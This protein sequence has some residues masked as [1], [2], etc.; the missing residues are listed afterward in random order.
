MELDILITELEKFYI[1]KQTKTFYPVMNPD[2]CAEIMNY[3]RE[4]R[5]AKSG[6]ELT[7]KQYEEVVKQNKSLQQ[8]PKLFNDK[9]FKGFTPE[10]VIEAAKVQILKTSSKGDNY[11]KV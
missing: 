6:I 9:I 10:E 7:V 2:I 1:N 5:D 8:Y 11:E 4:Y 3:L